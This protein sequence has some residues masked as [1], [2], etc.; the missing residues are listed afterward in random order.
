MH[1]KNVGDVAAGDPSTHNWAI[2]AASQYPAH[3]RMDCRLQQRSESKPKLRHSETRKLGRVH[4]DANA[5]FVLQE[6]QSHDL[7]L[8]PTRAD[9]DKTHVLAVVRIQADGLLSPLQP[10]TKDVE[11]QHLYWCAH[12]VAVHD[13]WPFTVVN[14]D[15]FP[16]PP[17]ADLF[18]ARK[19]GR[20]FDLVSG[21]AGQEPQTFFGEVPRLLRATPRLRIVLPRSSVVL[22][23]EGVWASSLVPSS[24]CAGV[25]GMSDRFRTNPVCAPLQEIH[26]GLHTQDEHGRADRQAEPLAFNPAMSCDL[27]PSCRGPLTP[28]RFGY[29]VL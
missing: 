21:R 23:A 24:F 1:H 28:N 11:Q 26:R 4:C 19:A 27:R 29:G 16:N 12:E 15:K 22:L 17:Q 13:L 25:W 5:L 7:A 9:A 10:W 20:S 18:R 14:A 3:N 8:D 2:H 6:L